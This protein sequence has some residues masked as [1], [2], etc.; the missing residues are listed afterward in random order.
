MHHSTCFYAVHS[1]G[2]KLEFCAGSG[3]MVDRL[4]DDPPES[5]PEGTLYQLYD[6]NADIGEQRNLYGKCSEV[7]ESLT[8]IAAA[9]IKNGRSTPGTAQKNNHAE[10]WPG[11]DW[12]TPDIRGS[13]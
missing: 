12:L 8:A 13:L 7:E 1:G 3:G 2:W 9:C 11:L 5:N 4:K 10:N 6:L